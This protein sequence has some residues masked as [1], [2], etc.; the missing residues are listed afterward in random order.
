MTVEEIFGKISG[1]M[2]QGIAYHEEFI[3]AYSFFG[4]WG[5]AKE[6]E[7]HYYEEVCAHQ[8][9]QHYYMTH[10]FKLI[11]N[12]IGEMKEMFPSAWYK[13][14]AKSVDAGTKRSGVKDLIT[15][16]IEWEKET[17]KLY[18]EMYLELTNLKE[19][20]AAIELE[21]YIE[22]VDDELSEAQKLQLNLEAIGY[23][24]DLIVDWQPDI[25]KKYK[26]KIKSL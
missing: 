12:E 20:A 6:Q 8:R 1:H 18:E 5:Y 13:Y 2:K 7:Y 9:L 16:W 25:K 14:S 10:Y 21:K 24:L 15:K 3:K 22:D 11:Q 4:L 23:N 17:K 19:A 26:G